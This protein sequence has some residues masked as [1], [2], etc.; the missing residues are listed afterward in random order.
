MSFEKKNVFN[1]KSKNHVQEHEKLFF[2]KLKRHINF[3]VIVF[4]RNCILILK[5]FHISLKYSQIY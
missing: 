2:F 1:L 3:L 4:Q 5:L